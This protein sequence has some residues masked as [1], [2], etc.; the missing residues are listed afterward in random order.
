MSFSRPICCH[1]PSRCYAFLDMETYV[2]KKTFHIAALSHVLNTRGSYSY[3]LYHWSSKP[4]SI[5][6]LDV[7]KSGH[8]SHGDFS[9][10]INILYWQGGSNPFSPWSLANGGFYQIERSQIL[11]NMKPMKLESQPYYTQAWKPWHIHS[12]HGTG[13]FINI[14]TTC[15]WQVLWKIPLIP[16]L[17]PPV[18]FQTR[19]SLD[20]SFHCWQS[21]MDKHNTYCQTL[22]PCSDGNINSCFPQ[23]SSPNAR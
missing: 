7:A 4:H 2:P 5:P 22:V 15:S 1:D 20:R 17:T 13:S 14:A 8:H 19:S 10:I 23:A 3:K 18:A 21:W 9:N 11:L 12:R 6:N 16:P